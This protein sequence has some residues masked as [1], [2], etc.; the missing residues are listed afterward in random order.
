VL[1]IEEL[2]PMQKS[3]AT[4]ISSLSKVVK[5]YPVITEVAR[6]ELRFGNQGRATSPLLPYPSSQSA[7]GHRYI[8]RALSGKGASTSVWFSSRLGLSGDV[9]ADPTKNWQATRDKTAWQ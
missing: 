9:I 5:L 8:C 3:A 7:C 2:H 4:L 6:F 1:A